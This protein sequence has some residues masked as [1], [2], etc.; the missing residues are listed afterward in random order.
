MSRFLNA[1]LI[2]FAVILAGCQVVPLKPVTTPAATSQVGQTVE[3]LYRDWRRMSSVTMT[4]LPSDAFY[5]CRGKYG[6]PAFCLAHAE[7][8]AMDNRGFFS[9]SP[10]LKCTI[11]SKIFATC[12]AQGQRTT[13]NETSARMDRREQQYAVTS[14]ATVNIGY[15]AWLKGSRMYQGS[16]AGNATEECREVKD[17]IK[18]TM[19]LLCLPTHELQTLRNYK[20]RINCNPR[21]N[22]VWSCSAFVKQT[23]GNIMTGSKIIDYNEFLRH[24][25]VNVKFHEAEDCR[26]VTHT[27]APFCI[28]K[29][30]MKKKSS[31]QRYEFTWRDEPAGDHGGVWQG[32]KLITR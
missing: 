31:S 6:E 29:G 25:K 24:Q 27:L 5:E 30:D 8:V 10:V 11:K 1:F 17:I 2:V 26:V 22:N 28:W 16:Y 7:Q 23:Q 18:G 19:D 21:G 9:D 32:R 13:T 3:F 20:G 4:G 15:G 14:Q 12:I